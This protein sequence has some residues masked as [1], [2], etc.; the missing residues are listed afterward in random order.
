[1]EERTYF[2]LDAKQQPMQERTLPNS[3]PSRQLN[4]SCLEALSSLDQGTL[5]EDTGGTVLWYDE[6]ARRILG[7]GAFVQVRGSLRLSVRASRVDGSSLEPKEWPGEVV[8]REGT[9]PPL[10]VRLEALA[11]ERWAL[12]RSSA[13]YLAGRTVVLTTLLD[14]TLL[15]SQLLWVRRLATVASESEEGVLITD[16]KGRTEW[17]N[18]AFSRLT[19]W[20]L[21]DMLGRRPD[22]LLHGPET[23]PATVA[24]LRDN[25]SRGKPWR[26]ELLNYRWD[27]STFW[28]DVSITPVRDEGDRITQYAALLRD[29]SAKRRSS[30]RLMEFAAAVEQTEDGIAVLDR[31]GKFRFAN[32]AFARLLGRQRGSELWGKSW[33]HLQPDAVVQYL[34]REVLPQLWQAGSWRGEIRRNGDGKEGCAQELTMAVVAAN[35]VVVVARERLREPFAAGEALTGS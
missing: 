17:V 21:A 6:A 2:R 11:G 30:Q 9:A 15:R 24:H 8:R 16:A 32:D 35:S 5:V 29:V 19:G 3:D 14:I 27:G 10:L 12:V 28:V 7:S 18:A 4:S 13:L 1:V 31:G 22:W 23:D 26:G 33:R 20:S 25:V 34:D